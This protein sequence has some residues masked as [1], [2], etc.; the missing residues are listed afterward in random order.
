V[1]RRLLTTI[2]WVMRD[3]EPDWNLAELTARAVREC[4]CV[5]DPDFTPGEPGHAVIARPPGS[6]GRWISGKCAKQ[7]A[8]IAVLLLPLPER[9]PDT[10]GA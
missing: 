2:P 6:T 9:P 4:G 8:R 3:R 1:F 10:R 7:F 5:V